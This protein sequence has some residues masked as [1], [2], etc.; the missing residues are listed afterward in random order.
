MCSMFAENRTK[1]DQT[2]R[3]EN[4]THL[5]NPYHYKHKVEII[6]N[7]RLKEIINK[8][9]I[10]V[11]SIHHDI[12]KFKMKKLIINAISKDGII[13]GVEYPNKKF[14]IGLQWHPEYLKEDINT[15]K[16]IKSFI[17]SI[18]K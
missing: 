10:S 3:L 12:V 7:T 8:K 6:D 18:E 1:F 16:L 17:N 13:E 2:E 9:E 11:N 14:I 4:E 5:D 15:K